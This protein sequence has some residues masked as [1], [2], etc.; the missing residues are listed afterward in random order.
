MRTRL[1][2][3]S[4]LL[5]AGGVQGTGCEEGERGYTAVQTGRGIVN[6]QLEHGFPSTVALGTEMGGPQA[7]CSGNLLT[8]RVIVS[9]AHCG[10][11]IPLSVIQAAGVAFFGS[12]VSAADAAI[13]FDNVVIH[14]DYVPLD[15]AA[16]EL[17]EYDLS[18]WVLKED[19]PAGIEPTWFRRD[20]I[21]D[22]ELAGEVKSVG[23][24]ITGPTASD[25]GIKRS[26]TL[27]LAD[28]DDNFLYSKNSF[29]PNNANICSGDSGGPQFVFQDPFWIEEAVHS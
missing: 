5:A 22:D 12:D 14:P 23:F 20:P 2:V 17:G 11:G 7:M 9:A 1:L 8:P 24:G 29:N 27:I 15:S 25:S 10:D 28:Y 6:G 3:V 18:V 4:F 13:G 26:A 21:T 19:A 16:G